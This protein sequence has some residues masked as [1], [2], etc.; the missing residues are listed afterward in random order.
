MGLKIMRILARLASLRN[1]LFRKTALDR[2]LDEE[3]RATE[4]T[5]VD[6]H[7]AAGMSPL[8]ARRAAAAALGGPGGAFR[9]KE[10]VREGRIG[11][12][13][14]SLLL[15]VRYAWRGL[16][17]TAGLT[18]VMIATLALGIG[19]NAAIFSVVRAMLI[20]P[21]PYRDS[22]RLVF[23]WLDQ[24]AV[25]YPRGP[26]SG[27]DL[28]N[29][30]EGSTTCA[31]FGAIWATGTVA[32]SGDGDP[33]Q[34]RSAFV[35]ANFFEVLGAE[36]ALGRTFR[37]E[38]SAPGA[39][40]A[41]LLGWDLFERRFGGDPSIVGRQIIVNDQPTTVVGVMPRTF[42]LL[43]PP[44]SSV[45]DHLQVWQPFWHD[46]ERGPRGNLF[47]RVIGR[48]RP[49]VTVAQARADIDGIASRLTRELGR[50][51]A[52][53][54][55]GLQADD[56]RDIRGP[57]LAL[58]AGV[59]MLLLI[60]CV[61][62]ASLLVARAA[63]RARETA[64]RLA[65]GAS[66]GR[67]LRQS[68]VE[69]LVLTMLG[70]AA[71][72]LAGYVALGALL[73]LAP[74][75]LS[76]I[77]ASR[78]DMPVFLVTLAISVVWGL[79]FSL[80]PAIELFKPGAAASLQPRLR[81]T[82]TPVR[83]RT[84]ATLV[85]VQIALSVVLLIGAGLLVRAFVEVQRV[86]L[87]FRS[88][89]HLT[90]RVALPESRYGSTEAILVA[91][92]ELR[93]RLAALPG[94]TAAGAISHLPYDDLP[95]WGL[96]YALVN[97]PADDGAAKAD[98]R[99]ISTGLLETLGVELLEG[100]LFTDDESPKNPVVIVDEMLARRLW[101]GRSALGQRF[102]IGQASPDRRVSVVGVIRHLRLRSLVEDLTPQI[103]IPYRLWQ[104][105]PMAYVVRTDRD[106][107][108]LAGDV[109][110]AVAAL[111]PR[112]PIYD[113]RT[114]DAYVEGARGIRRFTM[115]LAAVFA[116]SA[117]A[118]TCIGVYGV[119][120]YAVALR[121]HEFGVRRA[122]G[123]GTAQVMGEVLREGVK[124]AAAGSA[125]G[126]VGAAIAAGL[127]Q[128][129]LY[130]VHPRDP[131]TYGASLAVL[132]CGAALACW[133]PAHRATAISPMDALRE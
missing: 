12:G 124:F 117:L 42:R 61:N 23:V 122:L 21:L 123:A 19:A 49:G 130:A 104:R 108:A 35:T 38:D 65:L 102:L 1:T 41:I 74:E 60:A 45:P 15:D 75:T 100:R 16:S 79:L 58:L 92:R 67:L 13:L 51:R 81:S 8:A 44:D 120:A 132:L 127:L 83:Y 48:M 88:D 93:R 14:D 126:V 90:F 7:L 87:G 91:D 101:P 36:S 26:L 82:M 6:R 11:A 22:D 3:I 34:L 97:A 98:T 129:Q 95:N 112:L 105:S 39:P 103:F 109:R 85:I 77:G 57:L 76:R 71:G 84:R 133:I 125:A 64:L 37:S 17:T 128:S 54:T 46:L 116:A 78:M 43:L 20:E 40:P 121:R 2:D 118:L 55:V 73:A 53:T 72:V 24:A 69:G 4:E 9:V 25:G 31:E 62:V 56:V 99:S 131:F 33:E 27:P 70:A 59:G 119:L 32:L 52:F 80:A 68:L 47:L 110:A 50:A 5:L 66:R 30:R 63:S 115:L 10:D 29:L 18:A 28:R 86:D 94:V 107:S 96:T 106:P 114:M 89:R 113:V 111:D